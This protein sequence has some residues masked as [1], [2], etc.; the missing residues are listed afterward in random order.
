MIN[1]L[2]KYS[3]VPNSFIDDFHN[4]VDENY[5]SHELI[6]DFDVVTKWLKIRKDNL[7]H[8]LVN[9]FA[10]GTE[11]SLKKVKINQ[12]NSNKTTIKSIIFIT[13]L[14]FKELCMISRSSKARE[15]RSYYI[16]LED[17]VRKYHHYIEERL[18]KK[19]GL[20]ETNQKP[21]V[22]I[23]SGIIYIFEALNVTDDESDD[24]SDDK[25]YKIGK[26]KDKNNRFNTYNSGNA[27]DIEPLFILEVNDIDG[28]EKCIKNL[29]SKHQYRKNKEIYKINLDLMKKATDMCDELVAGFVRYK[30]KI[31]TDE[32]EKSKKM[33]RESDSLIIK[34]VK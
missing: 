30:N 14:C 28:V 16:A 4:I 1:F 34:I 2:K 23:K 26:T 19:I 24:E 20:L 10:L 5:S 22:N 15:V 9:N 31:G 3:T 11:Y 8:T 7:L 33:M 32:F 25:L 13:P 21:K 6:I 12:E 29:L 27:N 18:R 17:L